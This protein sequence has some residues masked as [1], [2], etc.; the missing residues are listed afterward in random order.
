MR[1][2][3]VIHVT[4]RLIEKGINSIN[5]T[6]ILLPVRFLNCYIIFSSV[7]L[8]RRQMIWLLIMIKI[9]FDLSEFERMKVDRIVHFHLLEVSIYGQLIRIN[10]QY[11]VAIEYILT[12]PQIHMLVDI[13][14][15]EHRYL[16][17]RQM[18]WIMEVY[19]NKK[20]IRN[21]KPFFQ[22]FF[23]YILKITYLDV[24]NDF[25]AGVLVSVYLCFYSVYLL[26]W[27][28]LQYSSPSYLRQHGQLR[29]HPQQQQQQQ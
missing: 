3:K 27:P 14:S 11:Q 21:G 6:N 20:R 25:A 23:N 4:I 7:Y 5:T 16:A 19:A 24:I 18:E 28:L 10:L 12:V 2:S 26:V 9:N 1:H 15:Q 13:S 8:N 22:T 29:K 17:R